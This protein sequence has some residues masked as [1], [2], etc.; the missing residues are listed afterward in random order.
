MGIGHA[1]KSLR[2]A[3]LAKTYFDPY[4]GEHVTALRDVSLDLS[5]IHI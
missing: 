1:V 2:L 5:L 4:K 3:H